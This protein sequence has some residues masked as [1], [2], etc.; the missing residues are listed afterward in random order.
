M[1]LFKKKLSAQAYMKAPEMSTTASAC[2]SAC[3]AGDK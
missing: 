2:G 3:G 1:G